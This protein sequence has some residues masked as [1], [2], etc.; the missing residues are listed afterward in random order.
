MLQK[1]LSTVSGTQQTL[2][3]LLL[4]KLNLRTFFLLLFFVFLVLFSPKCA[5]MLHYSG[6][7]L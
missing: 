3:Q 6:L 7:V 4:Q 2:K 5:N 1:L